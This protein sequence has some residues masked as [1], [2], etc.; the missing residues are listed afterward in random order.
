[1]NKK[2]R[3]SVVDCH[4]SHMLNLEEIRGQVL[5]I[6]RVKGTNTIGVVSCQVLRAIRSGDWIHHSLS[7]ELEE[8]ADLCFHEGGE[9][10]QRR[11]RVPRDR[12]H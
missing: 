2:D 1:M 3:I 10:R 4:R 8:G 6:M 7:L 9:P 5:I 12:N 11:R